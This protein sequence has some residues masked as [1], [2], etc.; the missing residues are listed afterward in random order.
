MLEVLGEEMLS[1]EKKSFLKIE[2][3][4]PCFDNFGACS[5]IGEP[6]PG[7]AWTGLALCL[8]MAMPD[9]VSWRNAVARK[10][11]KPL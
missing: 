1:E 8:G 4:N 5:T 10:E 11:H 2:R 9:G 3:D 7:T 6:Q